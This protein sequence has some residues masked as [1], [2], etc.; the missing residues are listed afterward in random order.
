[1]SPSEY[2]AYKKAVSEMASDAFREKLTKLA[3]LHCRATIRRGFVIDGIR[4]DGEWVH[5]YGTYG[6]DYALGDKY[7]L[8]WA[9]WDPQPKT[10]CEMAAK[11]GVTCQR[12]AVDARF[13]VR[14]MK[15]V[16]AG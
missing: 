4:I 2:D 5:Y 1:M 8:E 10:C 15:P 3:N 16:E 9:F 6:N 12:C 11:M 14:S 7:P 13:K